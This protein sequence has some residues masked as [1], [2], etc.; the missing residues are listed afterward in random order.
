MRKELPPI[1]FIKTKEP[2]HCQK[3]EKLTAIYEIGAER[4]VAV[5]T[6]KTWFLQALN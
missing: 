1:F 4:L 5:L 2:I 6:G 3:V